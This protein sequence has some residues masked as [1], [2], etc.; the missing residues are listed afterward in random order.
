MQPC[1]ET[2]PIIDSGL[3]YNRSKG[4]G[5]KEVWKFYNKTGLPITIIRPAQIYGPGSK[6]FVLNLAKLL[7]K[8]HMF[9]INK[10]QSVMGL[11]YIDNAVKGII[12]AAMSYNTIGQAYNLRDEQDKTWKEY[13][14]ALAAGLGVKYPRMNISSN[15]ALSLAH[16]MEKIY[17]SFNIHSRPLLTRHAV[18]ILYRDQNFPIKKAQRDFG[19][20]SKIDFSQGME[21]TIKW[22]KSQSL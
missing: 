22:L 13:I 12:Q 11:L 20:Q 17:S 21:Q 1:D 4:F 16:V 18:H 9:F 8:R 7:I 14:K 2:Y 6:Y 10:G 15:F 19:F 5:E 3:P